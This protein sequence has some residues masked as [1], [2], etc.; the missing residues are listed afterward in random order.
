M[1]I[2]TIPV[3]N[4]EVL[5]ENKKL[6]SKINDLEVMNKHLQELSKLLY[7]TNS[8]LIN[9]LCQKSY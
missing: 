3:M 6:K 1:Q 5:N 2:E 9:Q 8:D 4:F 7:E